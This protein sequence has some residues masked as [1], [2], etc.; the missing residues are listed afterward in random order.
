MRPAL[1]VNLF[2]M[3]YR[4]L[5]E[6]DTVQFSMVRH[7]AEIGWTAISPQ[8][9]RKKRGGEEGML[10]RDELEEKLRQFNE[11][12][13]ADAIRQVIERL[14]AIP[15]TIAGNREMLA[16]LRGERQKYDEAEKRHRHVQLI[17]FESPAENLLHVTWEWRLIPPARKGNRADMF[18]INGMSPSSSTRTPKTTTPSSAGSP[19]RRYDTPEPYP[20]S[21]TS[22]TCLITGTV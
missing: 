9:A 3:T 5:S 11:W 1:R 7:A 8:L 19:K 20:N 14:E 15:S 2:N 18:V 22:P 16:W 17:D 13:S 6:A 10:F 21:S 12:M 4:N